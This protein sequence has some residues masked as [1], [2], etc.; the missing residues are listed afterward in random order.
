MK[1]RSLVFITLLCS[2]LAFAGRS[3]PTDM[4][5]AILKQVNYPQVV[6]GN[7]GISWLKI[8]TLGWLS[9][10]STFEM[11]SS[12]RIRN[13]KNRFITRNKLNGYVGQPVGVRRN[14]DNRIEEI[15]ILTEDERAAFRS[16]AQ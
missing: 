4:D 8:L 11:N 12:V 13:E 15:W 2:S 6:L 9:N 1:L 16:R 5:M 3:L 10:N 14:A 7:D